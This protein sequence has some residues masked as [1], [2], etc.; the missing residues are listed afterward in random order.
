MRQ[1]RDQTTEP[2]AV[3]QSVLEIVS[4]IESPIKRLRLPSLDT[5]L[6][7]K[8]YQLGK[9]IGQGSYSKV[10][11]ATHILTGEKVA[12]KCISKESLFKKDS[13]NK[14][15]VREI[16]LL[17]Q[18]S[19]QYVCP[20]LEVIENQDTIFMV[21]PFIEGGDLYDY[22]VKSPQSRLESSTAKRLFSQLVSGVEYLHSQNTI[23]RDL[24]PE[25]ILIDSNT[26]IKIADFGFAGLSK[27]E[28]LDSML[29]S[30]EYASP[31]MI[32]RKPYGPEVD[33]W[34]MGVI[35]FVM[36]TGTLPFHE[37][38]MSK[39]FV[40]IMSAK[41]TLPD[42]LDQEAKDLIKN[43]LQVKPEKRLTIQEM[44]EHVW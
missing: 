9:V 41:Y 33:I 19:H 32:A 24:K 16:L 38:N 8:G 11:M 36:L 12:V 20:L 15:L 22:V 35:L 43:I 40:A 29:G 6:A 37:K 27:G 2:S 5:E 21:T 17:A 34:S 31:E 13:V 10:K 23:H 25:N 18:L 1:T 4:P 44:R 39:M 42:Y 28:P 14:Q 3:L 30:P 26:N 7:D